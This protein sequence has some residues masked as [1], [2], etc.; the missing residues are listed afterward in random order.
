LFGTIDPRLQV[1]NSNWKDDSN[2][3]NSIANFFRVDEM[4]ILLEQKVM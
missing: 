2:I 1:P 4:L 3:S